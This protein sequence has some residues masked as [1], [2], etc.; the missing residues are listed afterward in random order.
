[1]LYQVQLGIC[2]DVQIFISFLYSLLYFLK[3]PHRA[4]LVVFEMRTDFSHKICIFMSFWLKRADF[5]WWCQC[6]CM[7]FFEIKRLPPLLL[8]LSFVFSLKGKLLLWQPANQVNRLQD[9]Q[10]PWQLPNTRPHKIPH[11]KINKGKQIK[12][13]IPIHAN[14][15]VP[16]SLY[17]NSGLLMY[18][19]FY[20]TVLHIQLIILIYIWTCFI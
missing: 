8:H 9:V 20:S 17:Q 5:D 1:M 10:R 4:A 16:A 12:S 11:E 19:R 18:D 3:L 14:G 15:N 7:W 6:V 13:T 2:F